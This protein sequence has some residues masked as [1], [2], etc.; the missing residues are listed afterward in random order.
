MKRLMEIRFILPLIGLLVLG[1]I[2]GSGPALAATTYTGGD[3]GKTIT[4]GNGETFTV[5]LDENPTTGYSWD[6]AAGDGLQIV[7]DRYVP[8]ATQML[9]S[10]GYHEWTIKAVKNGTYTV[11]GVYKR[12]WEPATGSE[13]RFTLTVK[14][15]GAQG[16]G[17]GA[18]F[19]AFTS[20]SAFKPKFDIAKF[21]P[22]NMAGFGDIFKQFPK[23]SLFK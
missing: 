13:Q 1:L 22:G 17:S 2:L 5:K 20:L 11:S 21:K 15:A 9:G 19:P 8:N 16:Q 7:S 23:L 18:K 12:P 4:V 3:S 10:G 14:V 6:M